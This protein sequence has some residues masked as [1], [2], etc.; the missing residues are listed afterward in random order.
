MSP[1]VCHAVAFNVVVV[2]SDLRTF[3]VMLA[4]CVLNVCL[5]SSVTPIFWCVFMDSVVLV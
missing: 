5:G 3:V 2:C 4:K 1:F